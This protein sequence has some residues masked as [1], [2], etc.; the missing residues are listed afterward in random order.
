[1]YIESK[2]SYISQGA[3]LSIDA[4]SFYENCFFKNIDLVIEALTKLRNDNYIEK[5]IIIL[6]NHIFHF[7]KK[8]HWSY[9]RKLKTK[10]I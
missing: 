8:S 3:G 5:I 2:S 4:A 9:L 6:K 10:F 1:M 7:Q